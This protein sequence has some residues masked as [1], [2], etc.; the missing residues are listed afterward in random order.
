MAISFRYVPSN[1]R[2][3]GTYFEVDPSKANTSPQNTLGL[4]VG[5]MTNQGSCCTAAPASA[6]A[7]SGSSTL[8]FG[9]VLPNVTPGQVVIDRTTPDALSPQTTV[10]AVATTATTTTVTLS[11]PVAN[12]VTSGDAIEIY[13]LRPLWMTSQTNA[14]A[15]FGTGSQLARMDAIRR[16]NDPFGEWWVL[17]LADDPASVAASGKISFAGSPSQGGT[18]ALYVGGAAVPSIVSPPMT[19]DQ[20]AA[21]VAGTVNANRNLPVTAAAA[22]AEVTFTAKN[23]GLCGNDIDLRVNYYGPP[24]GEFTPPGLTYIITAMAG[25]ATNPSAG[26]TAGLATLPPSRW[27]AVASAYGTDPPCLDAL[28]EFMN[29]ISGE[30]AWSAM[31]YGSVFAA[32]SNTLGM[33]QTNGT[34]RN[35]QHAVIM[36]VY[37]MPSPPEELAAAIGGAV[38]QAIRADPGGSLNG[39]SLIGV[40]PPAAIDRFH[41]DDQNT[42]LWSGISTYVVDQ[43]GTMHVQKLITTYQTDLFGDPDDSY[44]YVETLY[45]IAYALSDMKTDLDTTFAGSRLADDGTRF[46]VGINV[47]TPAI[48]KAHIAERYNYLIGLGIVQDAAQFQA[49]LDVER[50]PVNRNR[51]NVLWP[52]IMVDD[53]DIIAGVAQFST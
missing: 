31:R 27:G 1:L 34:E 36:G 46:G 29:D 44:L 43:G 37:R 3:P 39:I 53:L 9:S 22:A 24:A 41:P 5:Q 30:W 4:L 16:Q 19:A 52:G 15:L 18:V 45:R 28:Q 6:A 49:G 20:I 13:D 17:P 8:A 32:Q 47:V 12:A 23:A 42:L 7:A 11:Q 33:L 48:I 26:L 35:D 14:K 10:A 25:G 2:V 51:V 21:A 50:D 38:Q 40:L